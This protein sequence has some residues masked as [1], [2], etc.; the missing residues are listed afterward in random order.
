M[1][2]FLI[3]FGSRV[4]ERVRISFIAVRLNAWY[5][6]CYFMLCFVLFFASWLSFIAVFGYEMRLRTSTTLPHFNSIRKHLWRSFER[7][8]QNCLHTDSSLRIFGCCSSE[9]AESER[10]KTMKDFFPLIVNYATK[11][12]QTTEHYPTAV[13]FELHSCNAVSEF[14]QHIDSNCVRRLELSNRHYFTLLKKWTRFNSH[15]YASFRW[16]F[17]FNHFLLNPLTL[18]L[19]V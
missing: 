17:T 15:Q 12:L 19:T 1:L 18:K 6:I 9:Q 3:L 10:C 8:T 7:R 16:K 2:P 5:I 13:S 4:R 11:M 14:T